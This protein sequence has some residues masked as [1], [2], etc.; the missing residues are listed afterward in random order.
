[1]SA[2]SFGSKILIFGGIGPQIESDPLIYD[3]LQN[4]V[5]PIKFSGSF[6]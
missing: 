1:M 4:K 5:T 6:F 3:I 2:I